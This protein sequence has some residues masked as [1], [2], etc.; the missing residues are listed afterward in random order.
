MWFR[1]IIVYHIRFGTRLFGSNTL[2]LYYPWMQTDPMIAIKVKVE[3]I[4]HL[5]STNSKSQKK[6]HSPLP[7][8]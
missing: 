4:P 2:M 1:L 5:A 8:P 6:T 7:T 3:I